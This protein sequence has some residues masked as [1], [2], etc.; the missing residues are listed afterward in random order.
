MSEEQT[1]IFN[2]EVNVEHSLSDLRRL[3][4]LLTQSISLAQRM[5]LPADI[6]AQIEKVQRLTMTIRVCHTAYA[7]LQLARMAAGDPVAW[8]TAAVTIAA[9]GLSV[10]DLVFDATRGT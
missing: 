10:S 6:D 1:V 3:E 7:M 4:G 5:G 9:A 8:G 2:L